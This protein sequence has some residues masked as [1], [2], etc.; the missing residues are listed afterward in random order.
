MIQITEKEIRDEMRGGPSSPWIE[1]FIQ[2][3]K[4]GLIY[5]SGRDEQ[6]RIQWRAAELDDDQIEAIAKLD[7]DGEQA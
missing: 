1:G 3:W 5:P 2:A 6:G 7:P 4:R